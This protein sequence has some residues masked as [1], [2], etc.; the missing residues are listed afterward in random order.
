[1]TALT[2]IDWLLFVALG[3]PA[4]YLFVFAAAAALRRPQPFPAARRQ[5]RFAVLIPA[6]KGDDIV[7]PTLEAVL[8][9]DYPRSLYDVVLIADHF[10]PESTERLAALP[11][12]LLAVAFEESSKAKALNHAVGQLDA[13]YDVAVILDA[14]NLVEPDFLQRLND[15][16]GAGIRAMQTHRTA[17]NR[18]TDTAVLDAASEEINNSVFRSGHVALGVS[19]AL[20]GSGMAFDY[21]WFRENIVHCSTAGEDKELEVLLLRRHIYID[22]LDYVPVYDEK[23]QKEG[24]FY[25]QRR[26]WVAAQFY[27]LKRGL[28]DLPG[29]L[30]QGNIDYADKLFQWMMP[31]RIVLLGLTPIAAIA[32]TI[33][34]PPACIKWWVLVLLLLLALALALPD[35]QM[36]DRLRHAL[37]K[38]PLLFLLMAANLFRIRG[39]G[40]RFIHTEHAADTPAVGPSD[41][42][43]SRPSDGR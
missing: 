3:I 6:Y 5:H 36:D 16:Y 22:Y 35:S 19:S 40:D 28:C 34:A 39:A 1:M 12:R 11:I 20:I 32:A 27:A 30:L 33:I 14:D 18:D 24:I 13:D 37:R 10:R 21:G 26:R 23:V 4:L 9:Q 25:N 17:R 15:A 29:A 43:P 2:I 7:Q 42:P 8:K 41:R 38:I 31:P